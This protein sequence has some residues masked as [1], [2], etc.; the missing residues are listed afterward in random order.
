MTCRLEASRATRAAFTLSLLLLSSC[1]TATGR[2]GVIGSAETPIAPLD[3]PSSEDLISREPLPGPDRLPGVEVDEVDR[4]LFAYATID[5]GLREATEVWITRWNAGQSDTFSR[6]LER[7]SRYGS[8]VEQDLVAR[9]LPVSLRYLPLVES[10][11]SPAAVSRVGATGLWQLMGPTARELGLTV[12]SIVDDRRDPVASTSAALDYLESLHDEFG[13][14]LLALVAYNVGPGRV[15]REL[16]GTESA[17][18]GSRDL[19]FLE[20][21]ADLPRETREFVPRFL[22]AAALAGDPGSHGFPELDPDPMSFDQVEVPDATSLDVVAD[23]AGV[24]EEAVSS[25]NPQFVRGYTPF[26]EAQTV[27][28][29]AGAGTRFAT[30]FA[31]VPPDQRLSFFG[32][33]VSP[34]ETFTH[35]ARRYGLSVAELTDTNH[36]VDPRRLQIGMTVMV[37]RAGAARSS[38]G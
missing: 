25:L 7:M 26:G 22:A 4:I 15:R 2:S 24:S 36:R 18:P 31:L 3:A 34:G 8:I 32:H 10:G 28:V 27:R 29:P 12:N 6:Y 5:P 20:I 37:P 17:E 16:A 14:W 38:G 9:G 1:Q 11:Y 19:R 13:S 33:V 23:A 35:I 30:N 21:R